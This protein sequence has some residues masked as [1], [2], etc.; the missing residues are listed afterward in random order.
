MPETKEELY[1]KIGMGGRVGFGENPA[2]LVIDVQRAFTDPNFPLGANLD[3]VVENSVE[4]INVAKEMK[5]SI[6]YVVV[7]FMPNLGDSG[8]LGL[9]IPAI[10]QI[11][12]DSQWAQLDTRVP[13][14][15]G[16]DFLIVKKM[17]SAFFGTPLLS[18]LQHYKHDTVITMG[19]STSGCVRSTV[20]DGFNYGYRM[21]VPLECVGDRTKEV[22]EANIFDI[23]AKWGD[24]VTMDEVIAYLRALK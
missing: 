6:I 4:V 13:Y 12:L 23:N 8:L 7:A 9:K 14:E 24:V 10:R 5:V 19:D 17:F 15:P 20:Q 18:I 22:H 2:V 16:K 21:I 3:E 1:A 11:T